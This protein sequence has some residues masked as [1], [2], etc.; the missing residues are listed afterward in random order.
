MD[1]EPVEDACFDSDDEDVYV[2]PNV[3]HRGAGTA[4]LVET[5]GF[6]VTLDDAG[7]TVLVAEGGRPGMGSK[8]M[9]SAAKKGKYMSQT[10]HSVPGFVGEHRQ[11]VLELKLIADVGLV[12]LPNVSREDRGK[13]FAVIFF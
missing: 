5:E 12:G 11:L 13:T 2:P 8:A 3:L 6:A 10:D 9:A 1:F 7:A 4:S